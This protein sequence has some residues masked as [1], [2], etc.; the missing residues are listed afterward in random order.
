MST[1]SSSQTSKAAV[2]EFISALNEN[3]LDGLAEDY[4]EHDRAYP[5][6]SRR[7]EDIEARMDQLN[8]S[9]SDLTISIEDMV[10][11]GEKVAVNATASAIHDGDFYDVPP[12]GE[13]IEWALTV[14]A[15]VE[16]GE[17]V[18]AWSLRDVF[19]IMKQLGI[20]P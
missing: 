7:L 3:R 5:G 19:G 4:V 8:G 10:T 2:R 14:F 18:E 6:E 12:T 20:T 15:R 11:E 9:L 13:R 16:E 17:V 1:G